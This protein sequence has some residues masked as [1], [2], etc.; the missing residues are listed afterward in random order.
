LGKKGTKERKWRRREDKRKEREPMG[1]GWPTSKGGKRPG[2]G[3]VKLQPTERRHLK[4]KKG[5]IYNLRLS[6]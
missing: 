2:R 3:W 4:K 6:G 1:S 5:E